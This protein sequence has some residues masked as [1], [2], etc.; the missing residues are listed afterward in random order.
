MSTNEKDVVVST[1]V[2]TNPHV[3]MA[4]A[5]LQKVRLARTLIPHFTLP[6]SGK[7]SRKLTAAAS[8]SPLGGTAVRSDPVK[9]ERA[10]RVARP[11]IFEPPGGEVRPVTLPARRRGRG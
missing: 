10:R 9:Y 5:R 4:Q 6:V 11:L 8:V 1:T 7:E 2:T 3:E